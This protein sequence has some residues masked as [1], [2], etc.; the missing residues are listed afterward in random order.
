IREGNLTP[1]ESAEYIAT[2]QRNGRH[3]LTIINDILDLS[4]IEAG[5]VEVTPVA[6]SL[7]EIVTDVGIL[8]RE[9]AIEKQLGFAVEFVGRLPAR[10]TT[11]PTRVRQILINLLNN[12]IKFTPHGS[13]HLAVHATS[14][15]DGRNTELRLEV[16]DTGPGVSESEQT[17]I[18]QPFVQADASTS[19]A[20]GG[21]GLGLSIS[22]KLAELLGGG[23]GVQSE[24]GSGSTFTLSI[25]SGPLAGVEWVDG[26]SHP[27]GVIPETGLKE[28][29]TDRTFWGRILVAED[30][31]EGRLLV[32]KLLEHVGLEVE[33]A[34]NGRIAFEKAKDALA[35]GEP[36]DVILM[37]MQMPVLDGYEATARLR[38]AGY[39]HPIIALT[40][41]SMSGDRQK[42]MD[43][44]CDEFLTKPVEK[45]ILRNM[46]GRYVRRSGDA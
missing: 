45:R 41:H 2:I 19:R 36:Y 28:D 26:A 33:Q 12:A 38:A 27:L 20:F 31:P 23:L 5:Q 11:D 25:P 15:D 42:C 17:R 34:E 10:I 13:V 35:H 40:A 1:E 22:H 29:D 8:M 9:R 4:K 6:V 30:M 3:L 44:G 21:T 43:A 32:R 39:H 16:S 46:V 37:D 18:F 24:P 14:P 7:F